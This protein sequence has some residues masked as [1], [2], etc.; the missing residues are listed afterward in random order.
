MP[1]YIRSQI[2]PEKI[3]YP[4]QWIVSMVAKPRGK[5]PEHAFI[6]LEGFDTTGSNVFFN[7]YDFVA[8]NTKP[9][10]K[11]CPGI[12]KKKEN[13]LPIEHY[14]NDQ[15]ERFF[16][17]SVLGDIEKNQGCEGLSWSILSTEAENLKKAIAEDE[18][19][20]PDYQ[21]S[22][23]VGIFAKSP[24]NSGHSC[25]TWARKKLRD[26]NNDTINHDDRL[27]IFLKDFIVSRTTKHLN[28][29]VEADPTS[30]SM[31]A[32]SFCSIM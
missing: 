7:R 22:G 28:M 4:G 5:N 19:D 9:S 18:S 27:K 11:N 24:S 17:T 30:P 23:D 15:L 10:I 21:I 1:Q 25:Y 3:I 26:L 32:P 8:S 16:W 31:K 6:I 12:V 20:P 14:D 2:N 29:P 13:K